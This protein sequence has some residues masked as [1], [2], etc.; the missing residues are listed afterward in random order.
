[1]K[2]LQKNLKTGSITLS[3]QRTEDVWTLSTIIRPGNIVSGKTFRKIILG[4]KDTEKTKAI[5]KPVYLTIQVEKVEYNT[6]LKVLG[7]ITQ[8]P[9]D[10]P[11]GSYHSFT[12]DTNDEITITKNWLSYE[13]KKI[14]DAQN[15]HKNDI[16]LCI[17]NREEAI[18]GTIQKNTPVV[19]SKI[20]GSVEKKVEG[21][22]QITNFFKE[23]A[24]ELRTINERIKPKYI[25]CG[26]SSFWKNNLE[27][28]MEDL[29]KK[30]IFAQV[31]DV[32]E[33]GFMELLKRPEVK[34]ASQ[35]VEAAQDA[36]LIE[37]I[38]KRIATEQAV[39]YGIKDTQN[40]ANLGAAETVLCTEN[41]IEEMREK[42]QFE[43]IE[44]I[45]VATEENKGKVV[46]VSGEG[47]HVKQ[48]D[49]LGG[50]AALLRFAVE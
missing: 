7:T 33:G 43:S 32:S 42:E 5:K 23:V 20:S 24:E 14:D 31:L 49:G 48:L 4:D 45:F 17:F 27:K 26:T 30:T 37:E 3:P 35:N 13:L 47:A 46:I 22:Q 50:I 29:S 41:L 19:L 11:R 44:S 34:T 8:G 9:E 21:N 39:S 36:E 18:F 25:I 28:E 16:L 15:M 1:M 12:I 38:T 2:I 6:T 40:A 10:M